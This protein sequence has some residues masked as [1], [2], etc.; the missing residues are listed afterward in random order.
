[1]VPVAFVVMALSEPGISVLFPKYTVAPL[2]LALLASN[3][4]QAAFGGQSVGSFLNGQGKTRFTLKISLIQAAVGF[5]LGVILI[6]RFGVIGLIIATLVD[7]LPSLIVSLYWI[8]KQYNIT[9]DWVSSVK[10]LLS[11]ATASAATYAIISIMPFGN[12]I[13]LI[14]GAIIFVVV[15]VTVSSFTKTVDRSDVNNLREMLTAL[16]PFQRLFNFLLNLIE[17]LM[18]ALQR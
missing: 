11:S 16:G 7:G 1:V 14:I 4:L 2:F 17:K 9:V 10:I 3:Y 5:P 12:W 15:L 6:P 13:R 18:I 8:N